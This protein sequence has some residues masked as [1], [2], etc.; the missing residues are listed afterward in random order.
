[1]SEGANTHFTHIHKHADHLLNSFEVGGCNNSVL[2]NDGP[3]LSNFSH[4][5][6]FV[7]PAPQDST[8]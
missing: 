5:Q 8:T 1:M 3:T 7:L 4:Q 6:S 2:E